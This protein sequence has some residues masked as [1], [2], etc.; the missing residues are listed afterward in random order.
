MIP[1][2]V[3]S[4]W[5]DALVNYVSAMGWPDDLTKFNKWWPVIQFAGKG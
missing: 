3:I 4:V 1:K 2:Q 5:F